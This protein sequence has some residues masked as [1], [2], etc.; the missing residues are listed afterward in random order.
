MLLGWKATLLAFWAIDSNSLLSSPVLYF[1]VKLDFWSK[2]VKFYFVWLVH[3]S[4][5]WVLKFFLHIVQQIRVR[6]SIA[7]VKLYFLWLVY[8]SIFFWR[9]LIFFKPWNIST[10]LALHNLKTEQ[11]SFRLIQRNVRCDEVNTS[12]SGISP[13]LPLGTR[14]FLYISGQSVQNPLDSTIISYQCVNEDNVAW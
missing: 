3:S 6:S 1:L 4:F 8:C 2:L 11:V 7:S 12:S 14:E 10:L 5:S 9:G 13:E